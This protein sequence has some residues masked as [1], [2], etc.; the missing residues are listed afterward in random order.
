VSGLIRIRA[1]FSEHSAECGKGN[2]E[3]EKPHEEEEE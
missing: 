2:G 3:V 1:I